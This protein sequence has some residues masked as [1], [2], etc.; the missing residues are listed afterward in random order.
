VLPV[1]SPEIRLNPQLEALFVQLKEIVTWYRLSFLSEPLEVWWVYLLGLAARLRRESA[2]DF[3]ERLELPDHLRE[4]LLW[5]LRHSEELLEGFFQLREIRPSDIYRALQPFKVEELLFMMARTQR[6]E[7]RRMIS[8][9]FHKYRDMR[10]ELKGRD[11]QVLGLEPG[12]LYRRILDELLDAR[13]NG[14]LQ[15]RQDE[16]D[17]VLRHFAA[18]GQSLRVSTAKGA[19]G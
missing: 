7:V 19:A 14:K 6:E 1:L 17:Y 5:A 10:T 9:Y 2:R 4:R 18:S 3:C 12:P 8:H 11:L 16:I 13:L 15:S